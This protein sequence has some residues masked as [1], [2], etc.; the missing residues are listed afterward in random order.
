MSGW[1][2]G[3]IKKEASLDTINPTLDIFPLA[4][5]LWSMIAGESVLPFWEFERDEN[6][7]EQLFPNDP[8][9]PHVNRQIL[10]KRIVRDENQCDGSAASFLADVQALI[11]HLKISL[12]YRP[13]RASAWSCAICGKG[14]Y[15]ASG[16]KHQLR[17]Y[18]QGGP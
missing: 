17:A 3:H 2:R 8:G 12:E 6:N 4:K 15:Q 9:M 14:R 13:E 5:V 1:L 16:M 7:L 10:S 18:R 11:A